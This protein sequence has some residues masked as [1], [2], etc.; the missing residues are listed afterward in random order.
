[1]RIRS[2]LPGIRTVSLLAGTPLLCLWLCSTMHAGEILMVTGSAKAE[3]Q[4]RKK[5][6]TE[7]VEELDILEEKLAARY[8]TAMPF[9]KALALCLRM[10][11][12]NDYGYE[13]AMVITGYGPFFWYHPTRDF[14]FS[15]CD[16]TIFERITQVTGYGSVTYDCENVEQYWDAL[17][18]GL[19]RGVPVL[20]TVHRDL[21]FAGYLDP[22]ETSGR[23][24]RVI[25]SSVDTRLDAWWSWSALK[26]HFG[27]ISHGLVSIHTGKMKRLPPRDAAVLVLKTIS[28]RA[29]GR[30]GDGEAGSYAGGYQTGFNGINAY[31]RD[32]A[33]T[34][35]KPGTYFHDRWYG[36]EAIRQ[37]I[38]GRN[39]CAM[40][41]Q[42]IVM[43]Q[44]FPKRVEDRIYQAAREYAAAYAAWKE[45]LAIL[46]P[47]NDARRLAAWQDPEKRKAGATAIRKALKHERA[48][49]A[50]I[51]AAA[52]DAA[53]L[54]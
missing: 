28:Y 10:A 18:M 13:D 11:G 19:D 43:A 49:V 17:K 37:Q 46:S 35:R 5:A 21:L 50:L 36:G 52:A 15:L 9:V 32:V 53:V 48:A 12:W 41:L 7:T 6:L 25:G 2:A 34:A 23:R 31:A 24:V 4:T 1:M 42:Q 51:D 22:E 39:A 27:G 45:F 54:E 14:S 33:N 26:R 16:P 30:L 20:A 29:R 40:Y 3:P 8:G 44:V 38:S 47:P